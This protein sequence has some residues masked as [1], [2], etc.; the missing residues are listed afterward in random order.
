MALRPAF[1]KGMLTLSLT[2]THMH[3]HARSITHY[4]EDPLSVRQPSHRKCYFFGDHVT[5]QRIMESISKI[6]HGTSCLHS[7]VTLSLG[8]WCEK[9]DKGSLCRCFFCAAIFHIFQYWRQKNKL[10]QIVIRQ[11]YQTKLSTHIQK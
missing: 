2:N 6:G 4:L 5:E 7:S 10:Q 3:A 8:M 9:N 1:L 11:K